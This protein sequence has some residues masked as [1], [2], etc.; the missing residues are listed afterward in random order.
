MDPDVVVK[1]LK[2]P[3]RV[4][5]DGAKLTR[6]EAVTLAFTRQQLDD[7]ILASREL[8]EQPDTAIGLS[9]RGWLLLTSRLLNSIIESRAV[10]A[11]GIQALSED[12][13]Q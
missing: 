6:D 13:A 9:E 2:A 3:L 4:D 7:L 10:V 8:W 5:R 12:P 1:M 11:R